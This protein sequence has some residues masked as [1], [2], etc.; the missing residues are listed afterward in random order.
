M[1]SADAGPR[2]RRPSANGASWPGA[3]RERSPRPP[4][5][6]EFRAAAHRPL[7]Q[8][9]RLRSQLY[10]LIYLEAL[11]GLASFCPRPGMNRCF[12]ETSEHQAAERPVP[13][14]SGPTGRACHQ[15]RLASRDRLGFSLQLRNGWITADECAVG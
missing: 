7:G 9:F 3:A 14:R 4:S 13:W 6:G 5:R 10:D 8:Y 2:S 15:Q 11:P 12:L 1:S